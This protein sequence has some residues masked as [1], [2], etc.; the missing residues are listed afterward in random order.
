[1]CVL[2]LCGRVFLCTALWCSTLGVRLE[3]T[4]RLRN[5]A[6]FPGESM[7]SEIVA[8]RQL[9]TGRHVDMTV[10]HLI[11][12]VPFQPK[13][14]SLVYIFSPRYVRGLNPTTIDP[15][16]I[17]ALSPPF[18]LPQAMIPRNMQSLHH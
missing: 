5:Q 14:F 12:D 10:S 13:V 4:I 7:S 15:F 9:I 16:R 3:Q 11:C 6:L 8:V 18:S 1:M 17:Q 2:S